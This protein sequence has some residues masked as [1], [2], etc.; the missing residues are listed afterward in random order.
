M[1]QTV[2]AYLHNDSIRN[3]N[4][5]HIAA[6][7]QV[8]QEQ[9]GQIQGAGLKFCPSFPEV[10]RRWNEWWQ[11]RGN[12]PLIVAQV[13]QTRDIRWD[14]AFD[15]LDQPDAW[16]RLRRKQVEQTRLFGE[17]LPAV[18]VDIGPVAMGA[19]MG[20]PVHFA[21]AEQTAW[22]TPVID[23]WEH[24]KPLTVDPDNAWLRKVQLLTQALSEDARGEYLVCLPDL[25]GAID[26]IANMRGAQDLCFDLH[27]HREAVLA[28]AAQ[29]VDAWEQ[30]YC[31][32]YDT[33]LGCGAGPIQWVTCWADR[34][35]TVP[36]CDFNALI[37]PDDFR[38]VCLPS[39][40]EQ[41]RRAGLCV[42]HLDGPDA[43][44][45][46]ETLAADPDITAIQYTPGAGTPSALAKLPMF[47]MFQKHQ[48]PLFIECPLAEARQL[49]QELDPRGCA[50]RISGL[51]SPG[52]AEDLIQW[53]DR[54]FT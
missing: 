31:Q 39:L 35:V 32:L 16:V 1:E 33:I 15:L 6:R 47:R 20:A 44:R 17:A 36:T 22:Q 23:S 12:T 19:F 24:A 53:R 40:A 21:G 50:I 4:M 30:V 5:K 38:D 3:A 27:E 10:A 42:L 51:E 52:Q 46:A 54:A 7:R 41:A 9:L 13:G 34:P 43:A 28:A 25:T 29:A 2:T 26:A 18:R 8:W 45:H 49:L 14:K 37:G 48:V 11:F